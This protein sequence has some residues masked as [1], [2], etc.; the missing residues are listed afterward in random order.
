MV[1]RELEFERPVLELERQIEEL[2]RMAAGRDRLTNMV[3]TF[4]TRGKRRAKNAVEG[5]LD[6]QIAELEE[7]AGRL[8]EQIF[9]KLTRWQVVQVAR[10]P[11]RPYPLDYL[12]NAFTDFS[13]LHGDRRFGDDAAIVGGLARLLGEVVMVIG[14]QKG[15]ST[16]ENV[17]RNFGMPRPEGYRKALRL[18]YLADRFRVPI[19][20]LI[21]T[22]GAYPGIDAEERGQSQAIAEALEGMAGL[23]VPVVSSIIGEGGSGGALAIGVANRIVMLEFSIYSVISPEGCASIL[24][25]DASYAERAADALRLTAPDLEKLG[26][27]DQIVPEP[28][29]GAHRDHREA[30]K[31]LATAV[32]NQLRELR[33]MSPDELRDD[34][35]QRFRVLGA[36]ADEEPAPT[37]KKVTKKRARK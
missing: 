10:H 3:S 24:F 21:D 12:Q 11:D 15:R 6:H 1:A 13:E 14:H 5:D 4:E 35:Y 19:V 25:K 37:K 23:S 28:L 17:K 29:G 22:P 27:V 36:L 16:Q 30:A 20:T 32:S 18:M 33:R 8:K 2:R 31:R 26:V 9:S 34:R 7:R